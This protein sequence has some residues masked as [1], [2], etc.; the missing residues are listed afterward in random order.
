MPKVEFSIAKTE[1]KPEEEKEIEFITAP[2][3]DIKIRT[4]GVDRKYGNI[5]G[6]QVF[7]FAKDFAKQ[8]WWALRLEELLKKGKDAN[9]YDRKTIIILPENIGTG[10]VFL[11]EKDFVFEKETWQEAMDAFVK[12]HESELQSFLPDSKKPKATWEAAFRYR[13]EEMAK[14]YQETFSKL[15]NTYKVPILAGS[16]ILPSPKVVN[17]NL[18]VDPKGPLYNVSVPFSADGRVMAPLL[19]KTILTEEEKQILEPGEKNQDRTW[20]VP[21]WKVGVFMGSEVF[22]LPLYESLRGRPL[23]GL[24]AMSASLS[25]LDTKSLAD[26]IPE[27]ISSLSENQIWETQGLPKHIKL[28]RAVDLVH[29]FLHGDFFGTNPK[30]RTFNLRDFV[31]ADNAESDQEPTILNLYF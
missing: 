23:D 27:D 10:L 15:A 7:L 18:V 19:K 17:G 12:K 9:I 28:T 2:W 5:V 8:E 14:V 22:S 25:P 30:G 4:N 1:T 26:L 16:I 6:M 11:G 3:T 21:G 24:V 13:S 31:N 20:I 29:V